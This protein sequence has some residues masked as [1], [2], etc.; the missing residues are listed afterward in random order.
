[1]LVVTSQSLEQEMAALKP[2][3][4][5]LL[6]SLAA[7]FRDI[8]TQQRVTFAT[9][10]TPARIANQVLM[11]LT[12][13][14]EDDGKGGASTSWSKLATELEAQLGVVPVAL[15]T[16]IASYGLVLDIDADTLSIPSLAEVRTRLTSEL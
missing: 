9:T 6:K 8:D 2:W 13:W 15:F 1:V 7:R 4:A 12:T 11:H 3:V 16:V 10:P 5:T 14:G